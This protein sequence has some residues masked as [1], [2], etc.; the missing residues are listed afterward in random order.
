MRNGYCL[1][2]ASSPPSSSLSL[3]AEGRVSAS[4]KRSAKGFTLIEILMVVVILGIASAVIL[5][6]MGSRDDQRVASASRTLM[7]D[8][9]YAQNRSIAYQTRHYVQFNTAT[10]SWQVMVDSGGSPGS[11]ITHPI[12]GMSYINTVGT[13]ALAKVNIN[14]VSFDGNTT[15]SFDQ[16]GVPYTW[17][18]AGGNVAMISGSIVFKAGTN[19]M[20]VQVAPYSGEITTH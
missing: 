8:L 19:Q 17:S 12:T 9:L 10:N 14:S 5:P 4:L 20:T 6:Q 13:G 18:A 7:A 1:F 15:I 16:M 11:I 3:R 2:P